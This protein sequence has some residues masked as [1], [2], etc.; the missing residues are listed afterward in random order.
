M[1]VGFEVIGVYDDNGGLRKAT[2]VGQYPFIFTNVGIDNN[3]NRY[4]DG[5]SYALTANLRI[6]IAKG[7]G[8]WLLGSDETGQL[9]AINITTYN[10]SGCMVDS[11]DLVYKRSIEKT[12]TVAFFNILIDSSINQD[13]SYGT[14]TSRVFTFM[15]IGFNPTTAA[16]IEFY[17]RINCRM[18]QHGLLVTIIN[19]RFTRQSPAN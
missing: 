6:K 7:F 16:G 9:L 4:K 12:A 13:T 2:A 5:K 19:S 8:F 3:G 17:R 15:L 14:V 10:S 11:E 18:L 1:S